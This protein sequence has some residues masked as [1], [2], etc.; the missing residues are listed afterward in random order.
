[1]TVIN[2]TPYDWNVYGSGPISAGPVQVYPASGKVA[3]LIAVELGTIQ[4]PELWYEEVRYEGLQ[5]FDDPKPG[6]FHIVSLVVA[7]AGRDRGDLL[8]PYKKVKNSEGHIIGC[9]YM[10]KV[11]LCW[12]HYSGRGP[13][14]SQQEDRPYGQ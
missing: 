5:E 12:T 13:D 7:I 11:I 1:M 3:R 8:T 6:V 2:M 14:G 9:R 4:G 10:Q